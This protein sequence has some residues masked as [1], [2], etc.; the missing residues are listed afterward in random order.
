MPTL[1]LTNF[2]SKKL[3]H[4]HVYTIMA[5]P[6]TWEHGEGTVSALVPRR[7]R[8]YQQGKITMEDYRA[9]FYCQMLDA[10]AELSLDP[11]RLA[12]ATGRMVLDGD[13]LCCTCSK[14]EA[15]AGRCHRAWAAPYLVR[16]G[17]TVIL[18]GVEVR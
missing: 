12:T 2:S 4:G 17:W 6:R 16:A 3:H 14:T 7:F 15:A 18:D 8:D 9:D 13:T 10:L 11:G 1:Y 5:K